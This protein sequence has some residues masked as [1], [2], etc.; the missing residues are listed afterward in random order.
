MYV[1]RC[2]QSCRTRTKNHGSS[3]PNQ[4]SSAPPPIHVLALMQWGEGGRGVGALRCPSESG[5]SYPTYPTAVGKST[6]LAPRLGRRVA[7]NKSVFVRSNALIAGGID[8]PGKSKP[9]HP[10]SSLTRRWRTPAA[11]ETVFRRRGKG[12]WWDAPC[13]RSS[14]SGS[15]KGRWPSATD[16]TGTLCW[17]AW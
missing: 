7:E 6:P 8:I 1:C 16:R 2:A 10:I 5:V 17:S 13:A 14:L 11:E 9:A 15:W 3:T 12:G 4:F